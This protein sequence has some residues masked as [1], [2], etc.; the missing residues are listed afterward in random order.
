MVYIVKDLGQ[1]ELG[2]E[3]LVYRARRQMRVAE[4]VFKR[5]KKASGEPKLQIS[6]KEGN[7][8]TAKVETADPTVSTQMA[9][10]MAPVMLPESDLYIDGLLRLLAD[11]T[12]DPASHDFI[13]QARERLARART[14]VPVGVNGQRLDAGE[15][16]AEIASGIT[17]AGDLDALAYR[18]KLEANPIVGS[19]KWYI[20]HSHS[21]DV[22][23]MLVDLMTFLEAE[24]GRLPRFDRD[25]VCIYCRST[26][27]KF[28]TAEHTL[29][30]SLGN[31]HSILPR[32]YVC[33]DCQTAM[34]AIEQE[35]LDHMPFSMLRVFNVV[36]TKK[37]KFPTATFKEGVVER[38]SPNSIQFI[39]HTKKKPL[40]QEE[41]M[42]GDQIRLKGS[43]T[44]KKMFDHVTVARVAL[45][46]VLG[47]MALENGRDYVLDSRFE[48]ARTFIR[49]GQGLNNRIAILRHAIPNRL[50]QVHWQDLP[51]LGVAAVLHLFGVNILIGVTDGS[52]IP[53][54]RELLQAGALFD[55]WN[56]EPGPHHSME[57]AA[58]ETA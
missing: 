21:I 20:F 30:E 52:Q 48:A 23:L 14:A 24:K 45:K 16:F 33:D 15:V 37:G 31:Y 46:G 22:Y 25:H 1:D 49:T 6:W 55:L 5:M 35:A 10:A 53:P 12:D 39:P 19:L 26:E 34:A 42:D 27:G 3:S 17:L 2:I 38:T 57:P 40:L 11:W 9:V 18:R 54:H 13:R 44:D 41:G 56:S 28:S 32:G 51:D 7:P 8:L 43:M 29:P 50:M 58:A 47:A 36:H 4:K